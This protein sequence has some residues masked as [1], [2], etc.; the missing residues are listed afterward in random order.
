VADYTIVWTFS[1]SSL[2]GS[3]IGKVSPPAVATAYTDN[4]SDTGHR[5]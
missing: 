5:L 1:G 2:S 3:E 4:G